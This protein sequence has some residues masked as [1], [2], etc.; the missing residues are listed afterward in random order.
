MY[1]LLLVLVKM[2]NYFYEITNNFAHTNLDLNLCVSTKNYF[3]DNKFVWTLCC[4]DF[5]QL[6]GVFTFVCPALAYN[7][8]FDHWSSS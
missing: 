5:E 3:Q 7:S 6:F 2:S 8:I 4:V 1:I